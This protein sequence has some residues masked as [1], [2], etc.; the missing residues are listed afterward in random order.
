MKTREST[1][2]WLFP[3]FSQLF[4]VS[5][6]LFTM[7]FPL[8]PKAPSADAA[9]RDVG[10]SLESS[11]KW[12]GRPDLRTDIHNSLKQSDNILIVVKYYICEY[13]YDTL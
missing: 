13:I 12:A 7:G 9:A 3:E 4:T 5:P 11:S 6:L 2:S 10:G 1:N 8:H